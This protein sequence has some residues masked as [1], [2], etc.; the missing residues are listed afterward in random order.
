[1][2]ADVGV[3]GIGMFLA[4]V[5]LTMAQLRRLSHV[6]VRRRP[7]M[8]ELARALILALVAYLASGIFLQ[9]S[10]QR[11]FWFLIALANATIWTLTRL[12]R[13]GR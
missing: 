9:L 13:A 12:E 11:Y 1:M 4:I 3:V 5:L 8:S 6:W 2:A 7:D 10:F